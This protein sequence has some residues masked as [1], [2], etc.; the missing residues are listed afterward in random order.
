MA[1]AGQH[2]SLCHSPLCL[3]GKDKAELHRLPLQLGLEREEAISEGSSGPGVGRITLWS[4][5]MGDQTP[6][7][8]SFKCLKIIE[9]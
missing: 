5:Y 2:A 7:C 9:L 8:A 4:D 1:G 6:R 3:T